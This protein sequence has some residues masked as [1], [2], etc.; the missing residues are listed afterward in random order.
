MAPVISLTNAVDT[1]QLAKEL[2]KVGRMNY[3]VDPMSVA[4]VSLK[5]ESVYADWL[6]TVELAPQ[7]TLKVN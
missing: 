3:A 4:Y 1:G 5:D 2:V 6:T 7:T